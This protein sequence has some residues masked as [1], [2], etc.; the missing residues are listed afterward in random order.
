MKKIL[1][2]LGIVVLCITSSTTLYSKEFK[3]TEFTEIAKNVP[4]HF[5]PTPNLEQ[6]RKED[7]ERARKGVLY[8]MGVASTVN[9]NTVNAGAWTTLS[10]GEKKWQLIIQNPGAEA[11]SFIFKTFKLSEGSM[12]WV[13]NKAGEKVSKVLT[14]EDALED[15][16]Q[17]IAL[18]YGDELVLTLI[19]QPNTVR[20]EL[21]LERVF[22]NYRST[23]NLVSKNKINESAACEV[24]VNC[25]E[26]NDFKDEKRGVALVYIIEGQSAGYCSG[27]LVNNLAQDCKPLFLTALHCGVS[28]TAGDMALWKFYFNYEAVDCTNP[29]SVGTLFSHYI[30]GCVRLADAADNGGDTGSDFLLLQ[31]GTLA[32]QVATIN[33]LRSNSINAYWNGWDANTTAN[34]GGGVGIHH[35]SGDIK[36]ISTYTVT[37]TSASF[38]G[39]V[40]NT[41]WDLTW[42]GTANGHGIT[43][44][45]SSGSPL[46]AY[47]GG[48]SR[49]IGTLTGGATYCN[50]L[51]EHDQ[52][53]K[54]SY[55]WQSNG[56]TSNKRLAT[57]L[58]P[59][60]TG[61]KVLNG[62][63]NPCTR[64]AIDALNANE[65]IKVYPNPVGDILTV[66]LTSFSS[67]KL[68]IEIVDLSGK[69]VSSSTYEGGQLAKLEMNHL[70]KGFYH[71]RIYS[72]NM[73]VIQ[74]VSKM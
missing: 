39:K 57:Y 19:D 42:A 17:N 59:A 8:R 67:K 25:T 36:K 29:T 44:E 28:T 3:S 55:H 16:Q 32:N 20:S 12:F 1:L 26:G 33:A 43:E 51:N 2:Y 46:F 10:S 65:Y 50:A 18:C 9:L 5:I 52:Y 7:T 4:V 6:I 74:K 58:D 73:S 31:L 68:V 69:L 63:S 21:N 53:G 35:P 14:N 40:Q 13:Q 56:A 38:G 71:I 49:I 48:S 47:N 11:L 30:N 66:D 54:V 60:N 24:N 64:A 70:T 22:F 72:D 62:S 34:T 15:F 37:P 27:S 23:G 45:G 61:I 41:H